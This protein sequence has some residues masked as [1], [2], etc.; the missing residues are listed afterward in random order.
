MG[1]Q[2]RKKKP[3][4]KE[5]TRE[6]LL[7][8]NRLKKLEKTLNAYLGD[9]KGRAGLIVGAIIQAEKGK[10]INVDGDGERTDTLRHAVTAMSTANNIK[11]KTGNIPLASNL[12]AY[13]GANWAGAGHEVQTFVK[14]PTVKGAMESIEDVFNNW[15]GS[16]IGA[17]YQGDENEKIGIINNLSKSGILPDG[18]FGQDPREPGAKKYD[19]G[20]DTNGIK[21]QNM[22]PKKR[23]TRKMDS[24]AM[25]SGN[26]GVIK[27]YM[28]DPSEVFRQNR[29][30]QDTAISEAASNPFVIGLDMLGSLTTQVGMSMAGGSK[31]EGN[32]LDFVKGAGGIQVENTNFKTGGLGGPTD[33]AY[34][35]KGTG[36]KGVGGIGVNVEK[37]EI[38]ETPEGEMIEEGGNKHTAGGNDKVV[39]KG[40]LVFS[41]QL[42]ID[43]KTMADRKKARERS[44]SKMTKDLEKDPT[45]M[46]AKE[47]YKKSKEKYDYEEK[48]DLFLQGVAGEMDKM[49]N[50]VFGKGTS[51]EGVREYEDGT[52]LEGVGDFFSG[53][54]G[55][56]YL[57]MAGNIYSG[58]MPLLQAKKNAADNTVNVN[59]FADYGQDA[60]DTIDE[61]G[62]TIKGQ[63]AQVERKLGINRNTAI[64]RARNSSTSQN[65]SRAMSL[66]ADVKYNEA[67]SDLYVDF[68]KQMTENLYRKAIAQSDKDAKVMTGA[69]V[70]DIANR[71]DADNA[72][73]QIGVAQASMG[74]AMQQTGKDLNQNAIQKYMMEVY[75]EMFAN[76]VKFNRA[77][78]LVKTV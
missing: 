68:S 60:I 25:G 54:T 39:P 55:G 70:A 20:T 74:Q 2:Q 57:G 23:K 22:K 30:D 10:A 15:V 9:P 43:G 37:G 28:P 51:E 72:A 42:E 16:M 8:K 53:F 77:G 66:G 50:A 58:L 61:A 40:T 56:D 59:Q 14:E 1:K 41:D 45:D 6:D 73:T 52:P 34:A 62:S 7:K 35:A 78:D 49:H 69:G 64:Q 13:M 24:Y 44:L 46:I 75:G 26:T 47:T 29:I 33:T 19:K 32:N 36:A 48:Q 4:K 27:G 63:Q 12:I 38:L 11:D 18:K 5:Q 67:L 17:A 71:K 3:P 21:N 76:P 65:V 31:G